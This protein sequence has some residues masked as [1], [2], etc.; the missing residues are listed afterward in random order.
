MGEEFFWWQGV[1]EDRDDPLKLGRVRVR[2][3]GL[4]SEKL[5]P[6]D[7]TGEGIPVEALPWAHPVCPITN[8]N[9]HG[10][11]ETPLGPVEGTWVVGFS[12]DGRSCQNL[13]Y[14]GTLPGIVPEQ[15]N[16]GFSD[17]NNNYPKEKFVGEP[18]TNRLARGI[19]TDTIVESKKSGRTLGVQTASGGTWDEPETEYAPEYPYN[20][21]TE[22]ESGHIKEIDDTKNKERLHEYHKAGTFREIYP[23]GTVVEKIVKDNYEIVL[24]DNNI[25]VKGSV[26]ITVDGNAEV[27]VKGSLT[28]KVDGNVSQTI[29]G[30]VTQTV[31]GNVNETTPQ[32][33]INGKLHVTGNISSDSQ[34]YDFK[35]TMD[36]MRTVF[37]GHT[38]TGDSGG[39]TSPPQ[40][41]M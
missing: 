5:V 14:F 32:H 27:Y 24:G 7:T 25:Y 11:G 36:E 2:I 16:E 34:V 19:E 23:D 30:G 33:T 26:K 3:V 6:D 35:G 21:V 20:H 1:V 8:A 22:S 4:H 28:Q 37:N 40:S 10:I 12:R 29:N 9:M 13:V 38:H 39:T 15:K 18:D 17:P 31:A 41:Q